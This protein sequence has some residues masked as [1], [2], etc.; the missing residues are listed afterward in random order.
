ML[1]ITFQ[2]HHTPNLL[3]TLPNAPFSIRSFSHKLSP[4]AKTKQQTLPQSG[5]QLSSRSHFSHIFKNNSQLFHFPFTFKPLQPAFAPSLYWSCTWSPMTKL[6]NPIDMLHSLSP[7]LP[8]AFGPAEKQHRT[9][10]SN[11]SFATYC[12][13]F[14]GSS[15]FLKKIILLLESCNGTEIR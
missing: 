3:L 1:V 2:P 8:A 9:V 12:H 15:F 10:R 6:T 11:S 7:D 13:L 5:C 4:A 14:L